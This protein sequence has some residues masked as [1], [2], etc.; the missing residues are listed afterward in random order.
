M[1]PIV[2]RPIHE[3]IATLTQVN[4][5]LRGI[6]E[7]AVILLVAGKRGSFKS[8]LVLHWALTLALRGVP[9][10]IVSAEGA[11][12]ARRVEAWLK[13]HGR[14]VA[15]ISLP[16]YVHEQ[17]VN[18]SDPLALVKVRTAVEES[19]M[20]PE[21]LVIDTFSKNSGALDENSN[22][23]VKEFIGGL[24]AACGRRSSSRSSSS[25]IPATATRPASE[26]HRPLRR[27]PM[28]P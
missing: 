6:I 7:A 8:F 5:L 18:F 26:A 13:V 17:R 11:G 9:V 3:I 2:F 19:G 15:P 27:T 12:L 21:L 4:W 28:R 24:D 14:D 22:S 1:V 25:H 23:A 10:F 20:S 16:L